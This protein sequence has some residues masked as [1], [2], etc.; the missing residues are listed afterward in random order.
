ML[1]EVDIRSSMNIVLRS[2]KLLLRLS[3]AI[4]IL[5]VVVRYGD[6]SGVVVGIPQ[7]RAV[8]DEQSRRKGTRRLN[9]VSGLGKGNNRSGC[10]PP[11][12]C[13]I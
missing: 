7:C 3:R 1:I 9:P 8:V 12:G 5:S 6:I 11:A 2:E 4:N 10:R 13:E